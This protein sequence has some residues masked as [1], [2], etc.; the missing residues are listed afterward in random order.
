[1]STTAPVT[2]LIAIGASAGGIEALITLVSTL[3]REFTAPVVI[4]QHL[5]PRRPSFL[6]PILAR[7]SV[8]PVR[9]VVDQ[10][11]LAAGVIYVVPANQHVRITDHH[12]SVEIDGAE[13][14]KPSIDL[15]FQTAA[16]VFGEGFI[17]VVLSGLGSDGAMG[18]RRVK[19]AGGTVV[20]QN[21]R[22]ASYPAMPLALAP[23]TVDVVA[24]IESMGQLLHDLLTGAYAPS[25]PGDSQ[26]LRAL[27]AELNDSTGVDFRRYKVATIER[28]LQRRLVATGSRSIPEYRE[29]LKS[30]PAEYDRL[31]NSFLIKV[32]EF[33]RDPDLFAYLRSDV[34][35]QLV[36]HAARKRTLWRC[37]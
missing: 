34:I 1:M 16:S 21:P 18:A 15:L 4:A 9:T 12:L 5:D 29:Y 26:Q 30:H 31:I 32:T 8:L 37:W 10:E 27:L 25:G 24:D 36:D 7:N 23:T 22:T 20:I 14:S 2:Q 3:P 28:R 11:E 13:R 6:E 35:P 33:F 17:A 19:E